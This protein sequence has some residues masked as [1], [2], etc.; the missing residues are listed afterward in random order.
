VSTDNVKRQDIKHVAR[1]IC[2]CVRV[3]VHVYI[4]MPCNRIS[5]THGCF[6]D[7]SLDQT[8]SL[9]IC[10]KVICYEGTNILRIKV[11]DGIIEWVT[12][13]SLILLY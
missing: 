6:L 7:L 2:S 13:D 3:D 9:N 5:I 12:C 10:T 1:H 11:A 4:Q 8:G